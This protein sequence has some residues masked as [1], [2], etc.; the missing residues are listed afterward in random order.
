M[1]IPDQLE[2][3]TIADEPNP[4]IAGA[5]ILWS[6]RHPAPKPSKKASGKVSVDHSAFQPILARLQERGTAELPMLIA[7]LGDYRHQLE[8]IDPDSLGPDEALA[9][10]LNL[11]N[12]GA[13]SLAAKAY[14]K[15]LN[16]VLRVP[17]GFSKPFVKVAGKPLSMDAIEHAKI[18]RFKDPRIHAAL[19][20]GSVSCPTLRAEPFTGE[21]LRDQLDDQMRSF[22]A[23]GGA[24][25]TDGR[26][27]LGR[28]FL[29]YGGDI[30][31][32]Y[33]MPTFVP[34][35]SE[36]V[37]RSLAG[38]ME[39]R[40]ANWVMG[41]ELSVDYAPYDWSLGCAIG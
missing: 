4:I 32:P 2:G 19:V 14:S 16:S 41:P 17:G 34:A 37:A 39:P 18:R 11:Y 20:C 9:Y 6:L 22:L 29:W 5:S 38:W 33:R 36:S 27:W 40:L 13:L 25:L 21:G 23:A 7:E 1:Q 24:Q 28:V 30:V 10:W 35:K 15:D 12:A 31:R 3:E 8:D 26:L